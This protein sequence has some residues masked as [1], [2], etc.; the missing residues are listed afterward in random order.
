[1]I[2]PEKN[3][4]NHL[5]KQIIVQTNGSKNDGHESGKASTVITSGRYSY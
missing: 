3:H 4:G 5:I 1:M 2:N